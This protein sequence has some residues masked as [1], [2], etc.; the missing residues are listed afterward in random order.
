LGFSEGD[1]LR[2]ERQLRDMGVLVYVACSESEGTTRAI[3][4]L[5][6]TGA[7]ETAALEKEVALQAVA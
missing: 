1:A 7:R 3:E 2:F 6:R 4:L 5:R